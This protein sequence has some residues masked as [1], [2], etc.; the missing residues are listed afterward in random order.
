MALLQTPKLNMADQYDAAGHDGHVVESQ[1]P[2]KKSVGEYCRTRFS[3]L[4]PPMHK[5]P[6]PFK[7][8]AMLNGKQWLFFF[9]GFV[10]WTWDAFDF[11]TVSLTVS[12]L[13]EEFDK[14]T[15]EI[16]WGITL[17][18]M[19]RSVGSILF[20]LAADRYG[21]KW[22]FI[23]NNLLFIALELG[24][25]F[26]R[27]YKEFLACRALF[28]VAMGGLYGN[29]AATALEDCPEEA[30]GLISGILQ[31]GYAFGYL[32]ATAFA[33]GLVNTTSHGWR[34]LFW[35]GA[36]PPVLI[37]IFRL[38]LPETDAY[39][40]RVLVRNERGNIGATFLAEGKVALREHWL[41]LIYLVLLMAGFNFM[42][43]G[44][45]DLY[46]TM[47]KNQYNFSPNA[48]TVIQVVANLGAMTG[49]TIIGYCS[50]IFGRRFSIIFISIIGGALLYPYTYTSSSAIIAAAF[51]EQFCVQGAWGVIPIHLMEL[52]PG[53]FRTFVVGTAYQ[54]GNLVS[55]ASSTIEAQ[56]GEKFPLPPKGKTAR[57]EYGKV[58]CIFLGCVYVYVIVLTFVGPE[59]LRRS[60]DVQHDSDLAAAAGHDTIEK[61]IKKM[62]GNGVSGVDG[63]SVV[64]VD[65]GLEK[66]VARNIE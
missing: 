24:T 18:L 29:A 38:C 33:R 13:A 51:F 41:L 53:S 60:F 23:V 47:L 30:R 1:S 4:K 35:F 15:T 11:F 6:N 2:A 45:Q 21:R 22:P 50:Q 31:Q 9:V 64:D 26:C 14:T 49:G 48:V 61:S 36:C 19:L 3:T 32:L 10:A 56:L 34:P 63:E 5:A 28:G 17:V 16:T 8:L 25:G 62:R 55:S 59:Y 40:E 57:F 65:G 20:G 37:I 43:H 7:L 44:S 46:P 42:S 39:N 12:D 52:S 27:T 66:G 58:V 54:L